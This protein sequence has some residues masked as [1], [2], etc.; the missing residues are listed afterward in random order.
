MNIL[1]K[2]L[3]QRERI[4]PLQ[5]ANELNNNIS[6]P[7][8]T[9]KDIDKIVTKAIYPEDANSLYKFGLQ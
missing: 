8:Y 5:I 7:K 9:E 6:P 3:I 2:E 4:Y 1:K